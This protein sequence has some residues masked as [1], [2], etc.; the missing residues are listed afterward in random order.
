M[1]VYFEDTDLSGVVYHANYLRYMERARS[2]ML[3]VAGIDQRAAHEA[4]QGA[5]VVTDIGIRYAASA[6]LD[7]DLVV[8]SRLIEVSA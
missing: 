8:T 3:R 2:D 6:R 4:G 7:D 5:Y 1:R